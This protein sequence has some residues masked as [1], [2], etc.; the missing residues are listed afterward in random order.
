MREARVVG[1]LQRVGDAREEA[2]QVAG[3]AGASVRMGEVARVR[4]R[5]R[6]PVP[7]LVQQ[8]RERDALDELHGARPGVVL[9]AHGVDA[10]D[11]RVLEATGRERLALEALAGPRRLRHAREEHLQGHPAACARLDGLVDDRPRRRVRSPGGSRTDR[12]CAGVGPGNAL[13]SA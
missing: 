3:I 2:R 11:A 13:L 6:L 4:G 10:H 8:G 12:A 1:G 7:Q 5:P 9:A